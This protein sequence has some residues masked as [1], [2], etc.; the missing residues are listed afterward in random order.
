MSQDNFLKAVDWAKARGLFLHPGLERKSVNGV[1]GM[2]ATSPIAANTLLASFPIDKLLELSN[3]PFKEDAEDVGLNWIYTAALEIKN[4]SKTYSGI[5]SGFESLDKMRNYSSYFCSNDELTLLQKMSPTLLR[6]VLDAKRK[7]DD[8]INKIQAYDPSLD[9]ELLLTIYLNYRSRAFHPLGIVPVLDQFNHSDQFGQENTL[10]D[11][12]LIIYAKKDCEIG[13]QV[14]ISYGLKDLYSHAIHYNY[15]DPN[16]LHL[17]EFG[18]KTLQSIQ[19]EQDQ[20]L[21]NHLKTIFKVREFTSQGKKGFFVSDPSVLLINNAPSQG[22]VTYLK[23]SCRVRIGAQ[24]AEQDLMRAAAEL[25]VFL[26]DRQLQTN[27][28]HLVQESSVPERLKRFY[29]LLNK[30]KEMLLANRA[31]ITGGT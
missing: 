9:K 16:A 24:A 10:K 27:Q 31:E 21:L 3:K 22:L 28:V 2:Y 26:I 25:F 30:E 8:S 5:F 14:F 1:F 17:V 13:E 15:Y 23:E 7:A 12:K 20:A 19:N 18:K 11:G 6:W 29:F 4:G